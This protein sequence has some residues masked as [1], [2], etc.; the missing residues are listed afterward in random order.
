MNHQKINKIKI[1]NRIKTQR[2]INGKVRTMVKIGN[3]KMKIGKIVILQ[4]ILART[5]SPSNNY[6]KNL[7]YHLKYHLINSDIFLSYFQLI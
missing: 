7:R 6:T 5:G 4:I 2:K 3:V 1:N